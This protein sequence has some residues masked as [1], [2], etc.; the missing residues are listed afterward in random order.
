MEQ[1]FE[2]WRRYVAAQ[3]EPVALTEVSSRKDQ[4]APSVRKR[5][6]SIET[7]PGYD[8]KDGGLKQIAA[9]ITEDEME[10]GCL[11][12]PY[13]KAD[14][15]WGSSKNHAVVTH[16]YKGDNSSTDCKHGKWKRGGKTTS[17]KCGR[18]P[19]GAKHDYVC[20]T[21]KLR[22]K[23]IQH[24]DGSTYVN[25]EWL[26]DILDQEDSHLLE[27]SDNTLAQKCRQMGFTTSQEAFKNLT[28]TLN[29]LHQAMKGDLGR[30]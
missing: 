2:N 7:F 4:E 29:S 1:E 8:D 30:Q 10:E 14:G 27:S 6:R 16:G 3:E 15:T 18:K 22:E 26:L 24:S 5:K 12:N 20:K 21:G 25:V 23:I 9:G 13:R 17:H 28:L 19:S 11:G